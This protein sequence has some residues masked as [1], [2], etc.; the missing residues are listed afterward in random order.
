MAGVGGA[1]LSVG[2]AGT[3]FNDMT[4]GYGFVAVAVVLFGAW[5]PLRV[6]LGAYLFGVALSA[7][8]VLQAY[9]MGANQY[10]LDA[11]PYLVMVVALVV[12]A[13]RGRSST[14]EGLSRAL[15]HVR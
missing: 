2:Y 6:S 9:G 3:W 7:T 4:R 8:S 12:F 15:T 14:P 13:R 5:R 1:E 11:L 10:L